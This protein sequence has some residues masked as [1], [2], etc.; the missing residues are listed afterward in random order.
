MTNETQA[1]STSSRQFECGDWDLLAQS[2][3]WRKVG[4][5]R[6]SVLMLDYDGTLAPFV[7]ERMEAKL[8]A[9]VA[10]RL[11]GLLRMPGNRLAVLSGRR[12]Q[13]LSR[14]LPDLFEVELWGSHGRERMRADGYYEQI[15]PNPIQS[16]YLEELEKMITAEGFAFVLERKL[17]SLAFHTR[18]LDAGYAERIYQLLYTEYQSIVRAADDSIGLEWLSFDGGIEIRGTGRTKGDAVASILAEFP[19]DVPVAYLGDDQT[20]EDAFRMLQDRQNA[21]SVLVRAEPKK[22]AAR[23]RIV[24]PQ[25]L[26]AFFDK[27]LEVQTE[28]KYE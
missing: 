17:G 16:R 27:Y 25:E 3:W 1:Q 2:E 28:K 6:A 8:Y 12:V 11:V 7:R 4:V 9:G 20:D 18:G 23:W 5:A 26:L 15:P 14:L 22:T 13:E 24:P 10:E 19:S 21:A